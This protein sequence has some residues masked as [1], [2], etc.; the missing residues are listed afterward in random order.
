MSKLSEFDEDDVVDNEEQKMGSLKHSV[1]QGQIN[2]LLFS[3]KRFRILPEL[4]LDVGSLDLSQF[5][6]KAK[7]ELI[8]DMCLYPVGHLKKRGRD[9]LK[10]SELPLLAIEVISPKQ[11]SDDILAKFEAYFTLGV[12]S[13]WLVDPSVDVVHV[14]PQMD[15]HKTFDMSDTEVID[16]V[17]DIRL[18]IREIFEW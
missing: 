7:T 2:G 9:L 12:K 8:P 11:G 6:L 17:M 18:P 1:V 10:V 3:E 14:Y 15:Q 16:E 13:C 4:T 5:G